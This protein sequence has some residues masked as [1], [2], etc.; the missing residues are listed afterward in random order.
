MLKSMTGYA[1]YIHSFSEGEILLELQS[2][3]RRHLDVKTFL[4]RELL[5]AEGDLVKAVKK[6]VSRG[7]ITLSIRI[8]KQKELLKECVL[9][10]SLLQSIHAQL[11]QYA[12]VAVSLDALFSVAKDMDIFDVRTKE[13]DEALYKKSLYDALEHGLKEF[14][15]VK[16][17]EGKEIEEELLSYI[18]LF[19]GYLAKV[20]ERVPETTESNKQKIE[21]A[22]LE[23]KDAIGDESIARIEQE[24]AFLS[25]RGDI[26]EEISRLKMLI[27][28]AKNAL[29]AAESKGKTLDFLFQEMLRESNTIGSKSQSNAITRLVIEMKSSIEKMKEQI[30]NVE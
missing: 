28:E 7:A 6:K 18:S 12:G 1:R 9:N 2:V 29:R 19:E 20:I 14:I 3:N 5:F 24:L 21:A 23:L 16:T 11:E 15:A 30:Q 13:V 22:L 25:I 27:E 10:E 8:E 26:S 4:P 17:R